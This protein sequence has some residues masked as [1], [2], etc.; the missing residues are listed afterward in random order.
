[1]ELCLNLQLYST[2]IVKSVLCLYHAVFIAI[3]VT[4]LEIWGGNTYRSSFIAE[5]CFSY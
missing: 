5:D 1:M 4:Q 2:V 3:P